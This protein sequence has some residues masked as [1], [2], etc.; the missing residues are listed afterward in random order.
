VQSSYLFRPS[1]LKYQPAVKASPAD[2]VSLFRDRLLFSWATFLSVGDC[3]R[4]GQ[5]GLPYHYRLIRRQQSHAQ[6]KSP[7]CGGG[8]SFQPIAANI[9]K[10]PEL[11]GKITG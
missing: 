5:N 1:S 7:P 11:F 2:H 3:R 6:S 4:L 9:A 10:L 8:F